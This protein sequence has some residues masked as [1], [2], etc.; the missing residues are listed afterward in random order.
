M[1]APRAGA[2]IKTQPLAP[3][4][5]H[6]SCAAVG[7]TYLWWGSMGRG[8]G[9]GGGHRMGPLTGKDPVAHHSIL[10]QLSELGVKIPLFAGRNR[11]FW[12][13]SQECVLSLG[14]GSVSFPK[15]P[16]PP[17]AVIVSLWRALTWHMAR[18]RQPSVFPLFL[19]C[20]V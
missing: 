5:Q 12:V 20:M 17:S 14:S 3:M 1:R 19:R 8:P 2:H 10:L 7:D 11:Y 4:P 18:T 13:H 9:E 15:S 6:P 16:P